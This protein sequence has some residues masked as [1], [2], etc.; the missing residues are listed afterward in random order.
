MN[1]L[2]TIFKT[3]KK[4][5]ITF[6]TG[7]DPDYE[8]SLEILKALSTNGSK[9][10]EIGFYNAES[11]ADGP[12]ISRACERAS[13]AGGELFKVIQLASDLRKFNSEV[14]IVL[15]G[16]ISNIFKYGLEKFAEDSAKAGVDAILVVDLPEE[17]SEENL[18]R[19]L[20]KNKKISLI[21]L[22]APNTPD[23]RIKNLT[24]IA[25]GFVYS[26]NVK[27][28]SG[29]KKAEKNEVENLYNRIKKTTDLPV[30]AGF[31]ISTPEEAKNISDTGVNGIIIGSKLIT[32]IEE[33]LG[34]TKQ[35]IAQK[36][37][38]YVKNISN[39]L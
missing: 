6:V 31:G 21:K 17:T 15:M 37:S 39:I 22:I 36:V 25:S 2:Q 27:G 35:I 19:E 32:I 28:V 8:T 24:S 7:C 9:I 29:T 4:V 18:L 10:C 11:A 14:G 1:R 30:C 33:N 12:V 16:Y 34:K 3:N 5:L 20:L 23:E 38:E 26:L 13:K